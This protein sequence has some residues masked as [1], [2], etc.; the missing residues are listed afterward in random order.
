[1][2]G[3]EP[4]CE[5]IGA[6]YARVSSQSQN[7][8]GLSIPAQISD[9]KK[10]ARDYDIRILETFKDKAVSGTVFPRQ[11]LDEIMA[12]ARNGKITDFICVHV[13]RI[14][15]YTREGDYYIMGLF[16]HGVRIV[17]PNRK[18]DPDNVADRIIAIIDMHASEDE[19]NEKNA[20]RR[21]TVIEGLKDGYWTLGPPPWGYHTYKKEGRIYIEK[22]RALEKVFDHLLDL[23]LENK[24]H[25]LSHIARKVNERY[26]DLIRSIGQKPLSTEIIKGI[27]RNDKY[28]GKI[29]Y[30]G[31]IVARRPELKMGDEAKLLKAREKHAPECNGRNDDI[32]IARELIEKYGL[33]YTED[34][35][36]III[37]CRKKI[38]GE[39]CGG[40]TIRNGRRK[41]IAEGVYVQN[42]M[43]LCCGWQTVFPPQHQLRHFTNAAPFAC[44][45][46]KRAENFT[47]N[48]AGRNKY[49][50]ECKDCGFGFSCEAHPSKFM[51][52]VQ[53][54]RSR[55]E[56]ER[57]KPP[58][59]GAAV[60]DKAAYRPKNR[61]PNDFK[62]KNS[63]EETI[64]GLSQYRKE[65]LLSLCSFDEQVI[66]QPDAHE[67][68]LEIYKTE[69]SW[70]RYE[71]FRRQLHKIADASLIK[72]YIKGL[73][74]ARG[75]R[76]MI[77]F[78]VPKGEILKALGVTEVP[79]KRRSGS[80]PKNFDDVVKGLT[81]EQ[82]KVLLS[83]AL[84]DGKIKEIYEKFRESCRKQGSKPLSYAIFYRQVFML[85][86]MGLVKKEIVGAGKNRRF[87]IEFAVPKDSIIRNAEIRNI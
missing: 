54:D 33:D 27:L 75:S 29:S 19:L 69:R 45:N 11:S 22:I 76:N 81:L 21:R 24:T 36:D 3:E 86:N 80:V 26:E 50:Y 68:Y 1:M 39:K 59:E 16:R 78:L 62:G 82:K 77:E 85:E 31:E 28:L 5:R 52:K 41:K 70:S 74:Q 2:K 13:N 53:L 51:R 66:T 4:D 30:E 25:S 47:V 57:P 46:C 84:F 65:V 40:K 8:K 34:H 14:A 23:L 42:R 38:L 37:P 49:E 72:I 9:T 61:A 43:C 67:R 48:K 6:V 35:L 12:L 10:V 63:L 55:E 44:P 87:K 20:A 64:D 73:G 83:L 56:I 17:T 32:D 18:Y 79:K 71:Y 60:K 15:R 58:D 7:K